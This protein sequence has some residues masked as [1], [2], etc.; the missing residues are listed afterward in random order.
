MSK[1]VLI[2]EDY[3]DSREFMQ[4][5]IKS[6]GYETLTATNGSEAVEITK[7]EIPDLIL[8]DISLP[9]MDG[10]TATEIIRNSADIP[11]M[12]IVAVTAHGK[13]ITNEAVKAGC[14]EVIDKPFD[15]DS[16]ELVLYQYLEH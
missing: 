14:N 11:K 5:L 4:L 8:M 13:F 15:F 9:V 12:P 2:V 7:E 6:F 1:K 16:L 3:E 10:I